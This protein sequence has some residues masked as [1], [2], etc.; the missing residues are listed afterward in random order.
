MPRKT[1]SERIKQMADKTTNK[2]SSDA[3]KTKPTV[4]SNVVD[5]FYAILRWLQTNIAPII[6]L[7][8]L[9]VLAA[10][11]IKVHLAVGDHAHHTVEFGLIVGIGVAAL[12]VMSV[13]SHKHD[14]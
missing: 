3:Q 5:F 2:V 12:L 8:L 13:G 9:G 10:D 7:P 11:D 14:K 4:N 1:I 6:A